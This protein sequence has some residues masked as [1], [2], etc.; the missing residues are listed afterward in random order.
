M[1]FTN[2]QFAA[3]HAAATLSEDSQNN[4]QRYQNYDR[5]FVSSKQSRVQNVNAVYVLV[6]HLQQTH[7][8]RL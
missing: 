3:V 6:W 8:I 1:T 2:A 7:L 5:L 4:R